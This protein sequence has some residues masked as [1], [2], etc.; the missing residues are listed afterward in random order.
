VASS[1]GRNCAFLI[2]IASCFLS[3]CTHTL[4]VPKIPLS[5]FADNEKIDLPVAL[6][7]TDQFKGAES[8]MRMQLDTLVYRIGENLCLNS[9]LLARA[10]FSSVALVENE[11]EARA[12]GAKAILTPR[13]V[14]ATQTLSTFP[15]PYESKVT[16][17]LQWDLKDLNGGIVWVD[18]IA[19][20][21]RMTDYV[22]FDYVGNR[23]RLF[24]AMLSDLFY[25]S[26]KSML[27][28]PEIRKFV[29]K[30]W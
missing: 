17:V 5:G 29:S 16:A 23:R 20:E 24:E 4:E 27:A 21:G 14:S 9:E 12:I 10:V 19:G 30:S 25:R 11:S 28:S 22:A 2:L 15:F 13:F 18:T 6:Y 7:F 26:Q 3:A 8:I 1:A